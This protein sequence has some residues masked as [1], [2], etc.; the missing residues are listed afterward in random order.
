MIELND[1]GWKIGFEIEL[2]A[3]RGKSRRDLAD[4]LAQNCGGRVERCLYPQSEP[5]AVEGMAS[6]D[7][8]ILGFDVI[9][10]NG[11]RFARCVDDLTLQ[12]DLDR[13]RPG[14]AGWYRLLSDDRRLLNLMQRHCDPSANLAEVLK[15]V[16]AV[17]GTEVEALPDGVFRVCDTSGLSI[18]LGSSLPG[19]RDRPC[20]LI[21]EP[22]DIDHRDNLDKL[23]AP[24][25]ELEFGVAKESAVHLHF[26]ATPLRNGRA[27]S[28]LAQI[29]RMHRVSFR[30]LVETNENNVRLGT[31]HK[32]VTTGLT[33]SKV[34]H[35]DWSQLQVEASGWKLSKYVDFNIM[36]LLLDVS[37]KNTV[38]VRILP[39]S[40]DTEAIIS[41]AALFSGLMHWCAY[42]HAES[43]K[44]LRELIAQFELSPAIQA[45]WQTRSAAMG[46]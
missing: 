39:G 36:N 18:A 4:Q 22:I 33:Q 40:I 5:S 28:R 30:R 16:A 9:G 8:L 32:S 17:F 31:W 43:P 27:L 25:R 46:V 42:D 29:V 26:D 7:N 10:Q 14:E 1:L 35:L 15:P 12:A 37:G 13:N 44:K 24:A 34:P 19:E 21:T 41:R 20:E 6:F 11:K 45:H 3:P 38:E 2:L 23:L